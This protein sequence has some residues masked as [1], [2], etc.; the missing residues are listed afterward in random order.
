MSPPAISDESGAPVLDEAGNSILDEAGLAA[1][2][3]AD[4]A[5]SAAR[6][7]LP[8]DPSAVNHADQIGQFLTT[9]GITPVYAGVEL[10]TPAGKAGYGLGPVDWLNL[11]AVDVDQPFTMPAGKTSIGRAVLPLSPAGDGADVTVSLCADSGGSPGA[12]IASVVVPAAHITQ[13]AAPDGIGTGGP[14][15]TAQSNTMR[16]GEMTATTWA[17]PA[18]AGSATNPA[19]TASGNY[20]IIAVSENGTPLY[21]FTL[22]WA[23]GTAPAPVVPQP[24]LTISTDSGALMATADTLV[25]AGGYTGPTLTTCTANVW[26]ASWS[27][28]AGQVQAWTS[29]PSL[30]VA[31]ADAAG[32]AGTATGTIYVIGGYNAAGTPVTNTWWATISNGQIGA[33]QQGP[34]LPAA[35]A[36]MFAGVVNGWLIAGGGLNASAVQ[37]TAVWC[38]PLSGSGAPGSWQQGPALPVAG[39]YSSGAGYAVTSAGLIA[40]A[41]SSG[42]GYAMTLTVTADGPGQWQVQLLSGSVLADPPSLVSAGA[43]PSGL[44]TWE[45]VIA[46][47]SG[48]YSAGGVSSV[49]AI[50]VPLPA[51]GLTGGGTY[52]LLL[53]QNGG[54]AADY[55]QVAADPGALAAAA[56]TRP[57]GGGSWTAL[58]S[59][60]SLFAGVF[61]P[62][63]G[64]QPLHLW[65]DDG[66]RVTSFVWGS[67]SGL[68][69]GCL[70]STLLPPGSVTL[71]PNP[72]FAG[73]SGAGWAGFQGTFSVSSSPPAGAPYGYAG[74][75]TITTG[76]LGGAME[77]SAGRVG[78]TPGAEYQVSADVWTATTSCR[79]GV[80]WQTATG[81][82][83]STS[84]VTLTVPASA[85][86]QVTTPPLTAPQGAVYAYPRVA[87]ADGTGNSIY[88]TAVLVTQVTPAVL[89]SVTQ[90]TYNSV[91]LPSGL[92]QL[93]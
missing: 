82:Y 49:P 9:H 25:V 8:G 43:F 1:A 23:G 48:P 85:W 68:L 60:Y 71:N 44:G 76:G 64:G 19:Q 93:A 3:I 27:P 40:L 26:A 51:S 37:Q 59:A 81:I 33:W 92:V 65:E 53:T 69:L 78:V 5:Y 83:L 4:P 28:A 42:Q 35:A 75:Y 2:P 91:G 29:Q 14:L 21:F 62:T 36:G 46:D 10:V 89:A 32:A 87:P 41:A 73:G 17:V 67:A 30:P 47:T 61:D 20:F 56:K 86:T 57:A 90:V 13:L 54:G 84:A 12:V 38:A 18:E 74:F 24:S 77:E 22:P 63:P 15:A 79:I 80:D 50:S 45:F 34:A 70:E 88:A 58:P 52:H 55:V 31:T 11:A 6:A 39:E 7:G 66:A 16:L 72:Y